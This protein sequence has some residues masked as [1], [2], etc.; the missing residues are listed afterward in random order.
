M[1]LSVLDIFLFFV[2]LIVVV[3]ISI[4]L[5]ARTQIGYTVG[6]EKGDLIHVSCITSSCIFRTGFVGF[7]RLI[8]VLRPHMDNI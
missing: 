2:E 8:S 7:D 3:I 1:E 6:V 5:V 4:L